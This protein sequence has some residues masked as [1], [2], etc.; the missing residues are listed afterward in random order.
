MGHICILLHLGDMVVQLVLVSYSAVCLLPSASIMRVLGR[1]GGGGGGGG[2][3][4][5]AT[6]NRK[7][8]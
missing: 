4:Q 2:G 5:M 6:I 8:L 7:R 3:D 1:G